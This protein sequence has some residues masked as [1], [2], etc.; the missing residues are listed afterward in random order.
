MNEFN[1]SALAPFLRY[2]P[3]ELGTTK[4][5]SLNNTAASEDDVATT[6][7]SINA[8]LPASP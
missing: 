6:D 7:P 5:H 8:P 3:L 1:H 4:V 2:K